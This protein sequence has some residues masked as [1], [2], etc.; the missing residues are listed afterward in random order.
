MKIHEAEN[1]L[2]IDLQEKELVALAQFFAPGEIIGLADPF[3]EHSA[4]EKE[5]ELSQIRQSLM[6][7]GYLMIDENENWKM[8]E[9]LAAFVYSCIHPKNVMFLRNELSSETFYFHF[10][11]N[12]ILSRVDQRESQRL[13]LYRTLDALMKSIKEIIPL[14][15]GDLA[16]DADEVTMAEEK[17]EEIRKD[18]FSGETGAALESLKDKFKDYSD[19]V[20]LSSTLFETDRDFWIKV[21]LDFDEPEHKKERDYRIFGKGNHLFFAA[22]EQDHESNANTITISQIDAQSLSAKLK[23]L[24]PVI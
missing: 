1:T 13:T 14:P 15:E 18:Y 16:L 24:I 23:D 11:P 10:L 3:D 7:A 12:W 20:Q 9:Y 6:D 5:E 8:D 21:G 4:D 17:W 22:Y 19:P 2:S